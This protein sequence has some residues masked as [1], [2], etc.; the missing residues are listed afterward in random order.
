MRTS[1]SDSQ[2]RSLEMHYVDRRREGETCSQDRLSTHGAWRALLRMS[3]AAMG[4]ATAVPPGQRR[5]RGSPLTSPWELQ[6]RES[7]EGKA[8]L[9]CA[10]TPE[11]S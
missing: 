6:R 4:A 5:K 11:K 7:A 8:H 3:G 10:I 1:G 2:A 9:V